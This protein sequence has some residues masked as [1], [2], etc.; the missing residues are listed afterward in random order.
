MDSKNA[1]NDYQDLVASLRTSLEIF[2]NNATTEGFGALSDFAE[3]I[4]LSLTDAA[5]L[6]AE[7]SSKVV[8]KLRSVERDVQSGERD[9][10]GFKEQTKEEWTT[11]DAREVFEKSMDN[12]KDY[13]SVAIRAAQFAGRKTS[14]LTSHSRARLHS[15]MSMVIFLLGHVICTLLIS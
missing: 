9:L 12:A 14:E 8:E 2:W 5:E 1:S 3:F 10:V 6:V 11:A 15:A 4:R 7:K 13:G